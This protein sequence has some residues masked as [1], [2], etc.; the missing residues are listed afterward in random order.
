M[1]GCVDAEGA[2]VMR[3]RLENPTPYTFEGSA[4]ALGAG[5][6][7]VVSTLEDGQPL[8]LDPACGGRRCG[9]PALTEP[10]TCGQD[11]RTVDPGA[12]VTLEWDG[13]YFP[14]SHD[15]FG[16]C[17]AAS[18]VATRGNGTLSVCGRL[19][20]HT[21]RNATL[22]CTRLEV[23]LEAPPSDITMVVPGG[24]PAGISDAGTLDAANGSVP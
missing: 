18:R 5:L 6:D 19:V 7:V 24:V 23:N 17:L 14:R 15:P 8:V 22:E 13:R 9:V 16:E 1:L 20:G 10:G 21:V 2:F 4:G 3:I 12:S 11:N